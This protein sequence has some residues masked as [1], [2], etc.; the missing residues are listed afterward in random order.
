MKTSKSSHF[1]YILPLFGLAMALFA[2]SL[3]HNNARGLDRLRYV[4]PPH[5]RSWSS[6]DEVFAAAPRVRHLPLNTGSVHVARQK[7]LSQVHPLTVTYQD[8]SPLQVYAH[9]ILHPRKGAVLIDSGLDASFAHDPYGNISSPARYVLDALMDAPYSQKAD[10]D[11]LTQL[12]KY[13]ARPH[14]IFFTHLHMDHTAGI[15]ALGPQV[16]LVTGPGEADDWVGW[17]GFGHVTS[18]RKWLELD[19]TRAPHMVVLGPCI[20]LF[21][22]GSLWAIPTPGHSKGHVSYLVM[23]SEG[24]I[25]LTGD[26]SHFNWAFENGVGA[27]GTDPE[28]AQH[29]L[30]RLLAFA[31]AYPTVRIHTGHEAPRPAHH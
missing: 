11:I 4:P 1:H 22:D 29:S 6:W 5:L 10:T 3:T 2:W 18:Q 16:A 9:L 14:S 28:L 26:A 23:D 12:S 20:D 17:F 8:A 30:E 13:K 15:P 21:G 7:N 25:L 24:P 19:F 27:D 31:A